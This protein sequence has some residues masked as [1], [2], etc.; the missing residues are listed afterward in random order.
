MKALK[1]LVH[2]H[3]I[4]QHVLYMLEQAISREPA[5]AS[6][7]EG[8][9]LWCVEFFREFA[10]QCHHGKEEDILFPLLEQRGILCDG[11][12]IGVL[13]DEHEL[14]RECVRRMRR[15]AHASPMDVA[16][17]ESAAREFIPLLREHIFKENNILF[18]M[19][20][21]CMN[22]ADATEMLDEFQAVDLEMGG[23]GLHEHWQ[24]TVALWEQE[25]VR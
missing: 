19:A 11:G 14:C 13:L 7:P 1:L 23:S 2:E 21:Q 22:H 5:C 8:F 4:I 10:D 17:F 16:A 3:D 25:F 6:A 20:E 24:N 9:E 12:P 15:A 18:P